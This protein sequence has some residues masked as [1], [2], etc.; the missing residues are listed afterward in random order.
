MTSRPAI[1]YFVTLKG[2]ERIVEI[3]EDGDRLLVRL[4]GRE[5]DADLTLLAEPSLHSL[6]LD[7]QSREMTLVSKGDSVLVSIDGE[8]IEARVL[9][10]VARALAEFAGSSPTG[11]LEIEAPMPGVVVSI[12]VAPGDTVEAGQAVVVLEAMKMQNELVA[13]VAGIVEKILVKVGDSVAGGATLVKLKPKES[14]A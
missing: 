3:A 7:G 14:A 6:L 2:R 1:R 10:E 11:A 12:G 13:E 8:T 4:D 5:V 9:D